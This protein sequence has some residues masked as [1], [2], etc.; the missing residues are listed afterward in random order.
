MMV[1]TEVSLARQHFRTL[2][3]YLAHSR[4]RPARR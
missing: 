4:V 2:E 3:R 1:P